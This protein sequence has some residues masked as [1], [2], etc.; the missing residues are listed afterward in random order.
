MAQEKPA[1]V[2][3]IELENGGRSTAYVSQ[4]Q[5]WAVLVNFPILAIANGPGS[6]PSIS[7]PFRSRVFPDADEKVNRIFS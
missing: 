5:A 3:R 2:W 7:S 4:A 1:R 6:L